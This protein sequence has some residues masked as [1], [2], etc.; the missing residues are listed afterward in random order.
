M[1][2]GGPTTHLL[3]HIVDG[4]VDLELFSVG[5]RQVDHDLRVAHIDIH[6]SSDHRDRV[7]HARLPR[8]VHDE[9]TATL[10][11]KELAGEVRE[12]DLALDNCCARRTEQTGESV[13]VTG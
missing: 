10:F 7:L 5:G 1:L 6:P 2:A 8:A 13:V 9:V 12:A 11:A 3:P 4:L